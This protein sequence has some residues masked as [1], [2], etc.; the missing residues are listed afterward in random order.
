[1]P[2]ERLAEQYRENARRDD[3]RRDLAG[4][5]PGPSDDLVAEGRQLLADATDAALSNAFESV[6]AT[7]AKA[8]APR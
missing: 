8:P 1:M 2:S 4:G 5:L 6:P 3:A 7:A